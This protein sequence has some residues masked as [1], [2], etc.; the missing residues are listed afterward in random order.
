MCRRDTTGL[1][2]LPHLPPYLPRVRASGSCG[3]GVELMEEGTH[4]SRTSTHHAHIVTTP[5]IVGVGQV[6]GQHPP[7]GGCAP[8]RVPAPSMQGNP[9]QEVTKNGG[10]ARWHG[11]KRKLRQSSHGSALGQESHPTAPKGERGGKSKLSYVP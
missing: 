2:L 11:M 6:L 8:A 7:T 10:T 9:L 5:G 4:H 3:D 1:Q